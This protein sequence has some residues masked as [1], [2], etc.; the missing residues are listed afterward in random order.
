MSRSIDEAIP[1]HALG[2]LLSWI[3]HRGPDGG[4]IFR[5]R[6]TA[7]DESVL[8]IGLAHARLSI[9]DHAGGF[10][11]MV[12]TVS[13]IERVGGVAPELIELTSQGPKLRQ[14]QTQLSATLGDCDGLL[15]LVFNG[16][17]Y[18]HRDLRRELET[19]GC[20]FTSD[21]SDTEVILQG[22]RIWGT[23]LIHRLDGMFAIAMYDRTRGQVVLMRD[24]AGQKPLWYSDTAVASQP[25][26]SQ[27]PVITSQRALMFSSLPAPLLAAIA[28]ASPGGVHP[29]FLTRWLHQGYDWHSPYGPVQQVPPGEMII[30]PPGSERTGLKT[31]AWTRPSQVKLPERSTRQDTALTVDRLDQLL[32][33]VVPMHLDAD[34]P[35]GCFLSGGI[36]SSLIAS[37]AR[38][39]RADLRA[40]TVAMPQGAYDESPL[41]RQ[42]AAHLKLNHEVLACDAK[43][44]AADLVA[45]IN[46]LGMPLG[47]SSLLPTYWVSKAAQQH[48]RVALSGDGGDELFG[49]YDRYRAVSLMQRWGG[50]IRRVPFTPD[51]DLSPRS[52]RTRVSRLLSATR[53]L[54][55]I[56]L[57]AIFPSPM[58]RALMPQHAGTQGLPHDV[59]VSPEGKLPVDPLRL[60]FDTYL[61][62]D[63]MTKVDMAS[64]AVALEVRSPLLAQPIRDAALATP[65]EQLMPGG[66]RKGL[67]RALARRHLPQEIVD[68]PKRGFAIPLG[69]WFRTDFGG[70]RSLLLDHLT[71]REPFGSPALGIDLDQQYIRRLLDEHLGMGTCSQPVTDHSQRL[72]MLLVLSIWLKS[73]SSHAGTLGRARPS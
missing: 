72:Y 68:G 5:D 45:L 55:Y 42:I 57:T 21:H 73:L 6:T 37:Y 1:H 29:Q 38:R 19:Q 9:L 26:R 58:L 65:L 61:P 67:L 69:D 60:D 34:V 12:S 27:A 8:D 46:S 39:H 59:Q 63:L 44:A 28:T 20:K 50:L 43:N 56:D 7:S 41:A 24:A 13:P 40:F 51:P 62:G 70:L 30:W 4:G 18:N 11:P 31:D 25:Q 23:E 49:G 71:S 14:V 15:A 3:M 32:Q 47:D 54:G 17:I 53:N 35:L 66:Q 52:R 36:D 10:Q 2:G 48:V 16:C 33:E 22:F 64:M